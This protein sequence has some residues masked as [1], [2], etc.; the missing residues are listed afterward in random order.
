M[1]KGLVVYIY[2]SKYSEKGLTA[3]EILLTVDVSAFKENIEKGFW[4]VTACFSRLVC[5]GAGT[6]LAF[7][8]KWVVGKP[9]DIIVQ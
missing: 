4:T 3:S 2:P 9:R 6:P 5:P 8:M 7:F 1:I